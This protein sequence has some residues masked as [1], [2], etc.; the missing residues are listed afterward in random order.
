[1]NDRTT[2]AKDHYEAGHA[3]PLAQVRQFLNDTNGP[4]NGADLA[5][6]D[7]FHVGG[8]AATARL[9]ALLG[10]DAG[11]RVLDAGSGL[12]GPSRY[13]AETCGCRV[14]GVDLTPSYVAIAALLAERTG[15]AGRVDYQVGDLLAL[16]F[17]D[18]TFDV[19]YTQHVVMNIRDRDRVYAEARRVLKPG[20][21]FGFYDVLAAD[22]QPAPHY[23]VPWSD[24]AE[25]S[26]LLTEAETLAA[27][28]GAGLKTEVWNDVSA[29]AIAWFEQ[30][31]AQAP[32]P[33]KPGLPLVMGPR[34]AQ[35]GAN[36][37]RNLAEHR[38]RLA[39]ATAIK[40]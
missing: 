25:T 9:V 23:P 31:R 12:G 21:K 34:F 27:L 2:T 4:L 33:H 40:T 13:V 8:L 14:T 36:F 1:M 35:M 37:A 39:M 22:G 11:Q 19:V 17:P 29:E 6:L 24:T 5:G 28:D 16:D 26:F 30:Q 3:D 18:A 15:T 38:I 10:I 32:A 20:G 7:Q